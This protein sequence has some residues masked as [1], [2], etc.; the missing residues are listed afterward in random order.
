M[1]RFT[2]ISLFAFTLFGQVLDLGKPPVSRSIP[3]DK[4]PTVQVRTL[5]NGLSVVMVQD[6]RFH[7]ITVRLS[8]RAGARLDPPSL[9]G[10]SETVAALLNE[11]TQSRSARKLAE[12]LAS[13]GGSIHGA[14]RADSLTLAGNAP[15]EN[16]DRLLDLLAD[17][18]RN[19]SFPEDEVR[20]HVQNRKQE[21]M[22]QLAESVFLA[23]RK[24][25]EVVFGASPTSQLAPTMESLGRIDRRALLE[26][27]DRYLAPNNAVLVVLGRAPASAHYE[28]LIEQRFGTWRR[29]VVT[30]PALVPSLP[31][32]KPRIVRVGQRGSV[33]D[34][35]SFRLDRH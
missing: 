31:S 6:R 18:A 22:A 3:S 5:A 33:Q 16:A 27:R 11:G 32:V 12:D 7:L 34:N 28:K 10:L 21:L 25:N 13:I 4:P 1:F 14:A 29:K 23:P 8:F 35:A 20:L 2:Q 19:A 9:P 30:I 24:L 17:V 26:F 15:P